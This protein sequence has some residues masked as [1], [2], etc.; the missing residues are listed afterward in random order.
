MRLGT[1]NDKPFTV[2]GRF[3]TVDDVKGGLCKKMAPKQPSW[4]AEYLA[5]KE[6]AEA[7]VP[8]GFTPVED[9]EIPF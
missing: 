3:E 9:A 2:I 8:A 5:E 7:A 6:Q 4:S 1:Y